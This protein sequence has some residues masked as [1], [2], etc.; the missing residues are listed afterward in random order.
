MSG[1]VVIAGGGSVGKRHAANLAELGT[2][3]IVVDPR[4][5]RRDEAGAL[6]GVIATAADLTEVL[7][8]DDVAALVVASPPVAHVEQSL[9]A[10]DRGLP[11][12]LEK[13]P[14]P[15]L[16]S[17]LRLREAVRRSG[18][19]V[20][21]G[22]TYRWWEPIRA[23]GQLLQSGELGAVRHV[24]CTMSAHLADWHPWERY[25][26]F[27][28][29][30]RDQGGGAL[31]DE[32]HVIDLM[33]W[34][35]GV[36]ELVTGRVSHVSDLEID[37]DDNVDVMWSAPEGTVVVVHLDLH[38]RPHDRRIVARCE[39]GTAEWTFDPNRIRVGR[40]AERT[41]EDQLFTGERNDMFRAV[42]Q[43]FLGV[44]GGGRA[45]TCTVDDGV[46][47]LAVVEAIRRS[48]DEGQGVA[49]DRC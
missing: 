9:M 43:E 32:S 44:V 38:A 7:Q 36:P 16:A 26:D 19:P 8:G 40:T 2:Q 46:A 27:F 39:Q 6:P 5:D 41:W 14:A 4:P 28:M 3:T 10:V 18:V 25:Q 48:S 49:V 15:D 31:L 47:V 35:F 17:A 23:F 33:L 24:T 11:V 12:L 37:C 13:P 34:W 1:T 45:P 29:S 21:L 20:L 42:T 22:Y 30:S